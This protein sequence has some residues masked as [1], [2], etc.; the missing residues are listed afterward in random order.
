MN[1]FR[2]KWKKN[3]IFNL[4]STDFVI[5]NRFWYN[6]NI[7]IVKIIILKY[8][9]I[10]SLIFFILSCNKNKYILYKI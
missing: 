4:S 7:Y 2:E 6:L 5:F 9:V 8:I 3:K 10:K 1:Y